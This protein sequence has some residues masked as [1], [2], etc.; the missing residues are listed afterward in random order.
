[1]QLSFNLN[2]KRLN[3][4]KIKFKDQIEIFQ[5]QHYFNLQ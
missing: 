1:M 4:A 2:S 3:Y 5:E